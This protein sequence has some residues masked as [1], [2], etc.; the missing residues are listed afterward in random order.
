M[1]DLNA[2]ITTILDDDLLIQMV[3]ADCRNKT[4]AYRKVTLRPFNENN[5]IIYQLEYH[6]ANKV[7][8]KNIA[9]ADCYQAILSLLTI[10]FK[11]ANIFSTDGDYQI[12]AAKIDRPKIIKSPPTKKQGSLSHNHAKNYLIPDGIACDFLVRLGVMNDSGQV[13]KKYY[14]KF[15]QINKFLEIVE[16][17]LEQFPKNKALR[18]I[19]FGCGKAY[20]TFAL[21]HYLKVSQNRQVQIIGLDLKEDVINFCNTIAA[22]LGYFGLNFQIGDIAGFDTKEP[23]DMVVTLHA[24]DTAT[25]YALI[26]AVTWQASVILSVPCCQ[27]EL[28]DQIKNKTNA[29]LLKHGLLKERFSAILTDSLR[30]LKLEE[31]GYEVSMVEFTSL[32][33]TAKNMMIK[34]VRT[35][36]SIALKANQLNAKEDFEKLTDFWGVTPTIGQLK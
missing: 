24:C 20:L 21:Y 22:D 27:H 28:F 18:I 30:G 11:K 25:D 2:L 29:S 13:L 26:K 5:Q 3:F 6:Y 32:E 16:D 1:K 7:L 15:R 31:M 10:D 34:A 33:H 17:A 36:K 35:D 14:A 9:K 23:A 19:D 4:Q 12:L 8:H